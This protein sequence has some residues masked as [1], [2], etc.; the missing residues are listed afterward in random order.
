M[1]I[2]H[3]YRFIFLKTEKTASSSLFKAFYEIA[4]QS[5]VPLIPRF[6]ERRRLLREGADLSQ[7]TFAAVSTG[8]GRRFPIL[9]GI[10]RHATA[11]QVREFVGAEIFNRYA[12]ITSERNPWDRQVS[13][14][15]HRRSMKGVADP[16]QFNAAMRSPI[17]NLLHHNRLN[18]W[19]IYTIGGR[20]CA[21][22]VIRFENLEEDFHNVLKD[23]G[24]PGPGPA[25]GRVR[26]GY[27]PT[28]TSYAQL[29]EPE[30]QDLIARWYEKE[31]A[32]FG[33]T[34]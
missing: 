7:V 2:S 1:I 19:G 18:N 10:H 27:R 29:Y 17:Y 28:S 5:D 3:R 32:Y 26:A 14:Y 31:I 4:S 20:V 23:L 24:I 13:L 16:T 8:I 11:R 21:T 6:A 33:Y 12:I 22:H 9:G 30:T 34:F 15:F 25:L